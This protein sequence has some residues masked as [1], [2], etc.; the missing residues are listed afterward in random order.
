MLIV[1]YRILEEEKTNKTIDELYHLS[2]TLGGALNLKTMSIHVY[3]TFLFQLKPTNVLFRTL[4]G[5]SYRNTIPLPSRRGRPNKNKKF[6]DN[7]LNKNNA[8]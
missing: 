5:A 3:S 2:R 7:E 4:S 8:K 1:I 6:Y